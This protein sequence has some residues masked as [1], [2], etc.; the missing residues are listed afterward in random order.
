M[1][2][3]KSKPDAPRKLSLP[4][5]RPRPRIADDEY[6]GA[7]DPASATSASALPLERRDFLKLAGGGLVVLFTV[8]D[9]PAHAAPAAAAASALDLEGQEGGRFGRGQGYPDDPNA[10]LKVGA[11]G[12]VTCFTGKIE[13]GQGTLTALQMMAADELEVALD[14]VDMVMGDTALCPY[15]AGTFGSRSI[16]YFGPALRQ[17]AAAARTALIRLAS[18]ELG[19]PPSAL[20]AKDGAVHVVASPATKVTYA[21]LVGG[22]TIEV[23]PDEL[24]APLEPLSRHTVTDHPTDRTDG[25]VKVTGEAKFTGD[26]R[27]PGL[28]YASILRPPAHG[29]KL[30]PETVDTSAAAAIPGVQIVRDGDLVAA[31]HEK[32]D[33]AAQAV[34]LIKAEFAP[35]PSTLDNANIFDHLRKV[36]TRSDVV[37]ESGSLDEGAR[38]SAKSFEESYYAQYVA[39][40]PSEPHVAVVRIVDGDKAEVWASTQSPFRNQ[41]DVARTLGFDP[42]NVRVRTPF[43]GCGFGGKNQDIQVIEAARLAKLSGKPVMVA[44]SR[45]E[46]FFEDT[47]R[48]ACLYDVRSGL[49]ARNRIVLWDFKNYQAGSRSSQPVYD[50]PNKR[51][52]SFGGG[53][54]GEAGVHPFGTG[55]WR[56][57]GSNTNI[58]ATESHIDVMAQAAGADPLAFRLANLA[59]ARMKRVV[60]AAAGK[61]ARPFAKAPSGRGCGIAVTD[62]LGTYLATMAEVEVDK[63]SGEVRVV[64]VVCAQDTGEVVNPEGA[65]MQI[66]GCITMGLGYC[67]TEEIRFKDGRILDQNFDTYLLPRMSW[68]P[69]IEVVLVPNPDLA[70]QGCGEPAITAMGAVIA[71]AITDAIGVRPHMLPMTPARIKEALAKK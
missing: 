29:A 63:A 44:W 8:G 3:A 35:S 64:R 45:K 71:N 16:K 7:P 61:F 46:E 4:L 40:A 28:V 22:R 2:R 38:L 62:Y 27:L 6:P 55:A 51:V 43:V 47:Y 24:K 49:D 57:P 68:L 25:R 53:F 52:L 18:A 13:M 26:I 31:L 17:A 12:R 10:Y 41:Q 42:P 66:E 32:P 56:G 37:V 21:S 23:L 5:P 9:A 14:S 48:P 67:F 15:D 70:P 20:A 50:I 39:H 69:K 33:V 58:F 59:D 36:S 60:E 54:G 1:T 65:R 34:A 30:K 11:D 19:A